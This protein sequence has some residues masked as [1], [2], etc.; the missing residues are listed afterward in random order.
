MR[1]LGALA[2]A[3]VLAAVPV[4]TQA[5]G[6]GGTEGTDGVADAGLGL[7]E[8]IQR[9]LQNNPNLR[10]GEETLVQAAIQRDSAW[11]FIQPQL[12]VGASFRR[13][14]KE[15]SFDPTDSFG[16]GSD[17]G[18]AFENL[19]G[20]LGFVLGELYASGSIDSD[21]CSTL[22]QINGFADCADLQEA[23]FEGES[24]FPTSDDSDADTT[25]P[26]VMQ[27]LEQLYLN[28]QVQWP[29]SPRVAPML[30]AGRA[31]LA[32]ARGELRRARDQLSLSI[33]RAHGTADQLAQALAVLEGQ[34]D[35][36]RA[37]RER[38]DLF[39]AEGVLTKDAALRARLEEE[40]RE[41]QL[42][43]TRRRHR[44]ALRTLSLLI[45]DGEAVHAVA[46]STKMVG[47]AT[48]LRLAE[49]VDAASGTRGDLRAAAAQERQ[50]QHLQV[51]AGLQFLP[52]FAL[53]AGA[54]WTDKT[55]GFDDR[56]GS[57]NLGFSV[58]LPVWDGG[59]LVAGAR[60]AASRRRQAKARLEALGAQ[61]ENE[62]QDA[63]DAYQL[64]QESV[65][66]AGLAADLARENHRLVSSRFNAGAATQLEVIDAQT[67][68]LGA[69]L[70]LIR[71]RAELELAIADLLAAAGLLTESLLAL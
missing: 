26:I 59:N 71:T 70:E 20:N 23:F 67:A 6:T 22:A 7:L 36:A 28:A 12:S 54:T 40:Q 66:I 34:R 48:E 19:Y 13:N 46:S 60:Q 27:H 63:H 49:L 3:L 53:N 25:D 47:D 5:E 45:G 29:L 14:D 44:S 39:V 41:R 21:D 17:P 43:D 30:L 56:Q 52:S 42:R 51:D 58:N 8:A 1:R 35:Q 32:G 33:V 61:V 15:V 24:V 18:D 37:H 16:G 38:I 57:W 31:Q 69:E 4:K 50:A 68:L 65:P 64:G 10:I 9:A 62:I 2:A 11:T 55:S